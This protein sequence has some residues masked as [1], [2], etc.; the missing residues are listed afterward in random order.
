[1]RILILA[2]A[3]IAAV[4]L[5]SCDEPDDCRDRICPAAPSKPTGGMA[6]AV[7]TPG[8]DGWSSVLVE[9]HSGSTVESGPVH[10]SWRI[11]PEGEKGRTVW[12]PEGTWSG[13]ALYMR[14]GDTLEVF[15]ADETSIESE[16]DDCGCVVDWKREDGELDLGA[17]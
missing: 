15:D 12:V 13:Y 9:I 11:G 5:T 7:S 14:P 16:E 4:L 1:M 10:S 6:L 3:A 17:R 8:S 2:G